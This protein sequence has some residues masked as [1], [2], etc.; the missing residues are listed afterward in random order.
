MVGAQS[1]DKVQQEKIAQT[2]THSPFIC[3]KGCD[4]F[5]LIPGN[6]ALH[7]SLTPPV[8]EMTLEEAREVHDNWPGKII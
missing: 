5:S 6:P 1:R 2:P 8:A 3:T 7:P 4:A